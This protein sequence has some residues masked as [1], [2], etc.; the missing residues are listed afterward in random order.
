M[1]V[2][3]VAKWTSG[4][5]AAVV[6]A[7]CGWIAWE[8]FYSPGSAIAHALKT[9]LDA[10]SPAPDAARLRLLLNTLMESYD[11]VRLDATRWSA[12]FWGFTFASLIASALAG[13]VLKVESLHIPDIKRRDIAAAL[14][15]VASIAAAIST[16]GEFKQRWRANRNAAAEIEY[17]GYRTLA[18]DSPDLDAAFKEI[19]EIQFRRTQQ[20]TGID[21]K[22]SDSDGRS[23]KAPGERR[24]SPASSS[25]ASNS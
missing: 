23:A 10:T 16:T 2:G 17:L 20:I 12:V 14:A 7:G 1:S 15:F 11:E 18:T 9:R 5:I 21:V 19:G 3:K 24:G 22:P 4:V 6:I 25:S 8:H 13:G